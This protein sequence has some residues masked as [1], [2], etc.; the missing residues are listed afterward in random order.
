MAS[1][2]E[3]RADGRAKVASRTEDENM[4]HFRD[5]RRNVSLDEERNRERNHRM[6]K[7]TKEG[8]IPVFDIGCPVPH[9][10]CIQQGAWAISVESLGNKIPNISAK[11]NKKSVSPVNRK[12]AD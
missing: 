1:I 4:W 2:E 6:E 12:L 5:W 7:K 3:M 11:K 8:C 10:G 9:E